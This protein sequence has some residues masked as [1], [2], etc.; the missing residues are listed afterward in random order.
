MKR[1]VIY[2]QNEEI[3]AL[4][5]LQ[6]QLIKQGALVSFS[7]IKY[8]ERNLADQV[9]TTKRHLDTVRGLYAGTG[10]PVQT[11][12]ADETPAPTPTAKSE[13]VVEVEVEAV[14]AVEEVPALPESEEVVMTVSE[15]PAVAPTPS[16]RRG[17]KE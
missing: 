10:I 15:A 6:K 17:S 11:I 12:D 5:P 9:L 7:A 2:V 3:E 13:E 1:I 8:M 4:R 14:P 16:R